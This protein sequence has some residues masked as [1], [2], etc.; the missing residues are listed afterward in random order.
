VKHGAECVLAYKNPKDAEHRLDGLRKAAAGALAVS[1][2]GHLA[3]RHGELAVP[4][5]TKAADISIDGHVVGRIC[6]NHFSEFA[7]Q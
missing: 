1:A 6:E 2:Q 4:D 3:G 7:G 5:A